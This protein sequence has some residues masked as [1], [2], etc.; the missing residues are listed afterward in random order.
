M[1]QRVLTLTGY[2][3]RRL[4]LS[5]AGIL[6][7]LLS[8]AFWRLFFSPG[9]GTPDID[10]YILV[11][12]LFGTGLTF[13]ITLSI[14]ARGYRALHYPI[15]ARLPSRVEHLTAVMLASLLY[16]ALLQLLVALLALFDGPTFS[17][18]QA[19]EIPPIWLSV[20]LLA[21]TLALHASD[22]VTA[23]WSRVYVYGL[24]A[25]LLFGQQITSG[26]TGRLANIILQVGNWFIRRGWAAAGNLVNDASRWL[27]GSGSNLLAQLFDLVFWPFRA[28][29][30]A[31]IA[32]SFE[33]LQ[34]LAPA[35][36]VL[37]ATFLF[38]LAADFFANKDLYLTE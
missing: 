14:A 22:L 27:N 11:I 34:A 33:P 23:G 37:Y 36:L 35:L 2:F 18:G 20:N 31:V 3:F 12:G 1:A 15:L 4:L 29:A 30:D 16:S 6:Y 38:M 8:L 21:A 7:I 13:L 19:L 9:Q 24:L 25:V 5:L 26:S 17:L 32:G 28:V 10:Y